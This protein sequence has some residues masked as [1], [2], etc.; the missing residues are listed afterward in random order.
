MKQ[1]NGEELVWNVISA[2]E[3]VK[4][5]CAACVRSGTSPPS[6]ESLKLNHFS[7]PKCAESELILGSSAE[8]TIAVAHSQ[9][10]LEA[11]RRAVSSQAGLT[12]A[13]IIS[14]CFLSR[15]QA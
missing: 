12:I 7:W 8:L 13:V 4:P 5:V 10:V 1:H 6:G 2:I 14:C 3:T 9:T 11:N 15:A